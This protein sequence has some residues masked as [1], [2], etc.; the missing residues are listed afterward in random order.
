MPD[1]ATLTKVESTRLADQL[2]RSFRGGAWHGP[3]VEEAVAGLDA[4]TARRRPLAAAHSIV[5]L[6]GHLAFWI[7]TASRRIEGS[8][9]GSVGE[10]EDWPPLD[11]SDDGWRRLVARLDAA[12]RHL[13][14]KVLALDDAALDGPVA[15]C[16]PTVRGLL[17]GIL[18]HNAY[19]GGQI[20]L[21]RKEEAPA[22]R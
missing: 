21:L 10:G 6:V 13:H 12:H 5:E 8:G 4:A 18:Q 22:A 9:E 14:A 16:D 11:E 15:G 2:E 7:E 1:T 20:V 3:S 17:L 19:H